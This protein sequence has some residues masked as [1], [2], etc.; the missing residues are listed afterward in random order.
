MNNRQTRIME[1]A[2]LFLVAQFTGMAQSTTP[3]PASI[4]VPAGHVLHVRTKATGT[5]NYICLMGETG[6]A[7]KSLG[8][9]ATLFVNIQWFGTELEQQVATH[10][11]SMNPEENGLARATWQHS[12][13][14]STVWAKAIGT[15]SDAPWVAEGAI[16]WLLLQVTGVS[17]RANRGGALAGTTY[18]Q[19]INTEGGVAPGSGCGETTVG[20]VAMVPYRTEYLFY[21]SENQIQLKQF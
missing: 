3:V 2:T 6:P 14:S 9:Q 19:R 5:Q 13:D 8:P 15:S 4:E 17:R 16:P 11:L 1:A 18:I 20:T 12:I 7:W 10:Y 21:R